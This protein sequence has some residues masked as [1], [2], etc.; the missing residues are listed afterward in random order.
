MR[1]FVMNF[2]M[3][4]YFEM[5]QNMGCPQMTESSCGINYRGL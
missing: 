2:T 1:R 4:T 3:R 5:V